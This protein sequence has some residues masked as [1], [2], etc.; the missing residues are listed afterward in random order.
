MTIKIQS[1]HFK[2]RANNPAEANVLHPTHGSSDHDLEHVLCS[3]VMDKHLD[4]GVFWCSCSQKKQ[5]METKVKVAAAAASLT[6]LC[7]F[8][9][10]CLF[11]HLL[12]IRFADGAFF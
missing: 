5:A 7:K 4:N 1:V 9:C 6:G 10:I 3:D 12:P 11:S 2:Q 8:A